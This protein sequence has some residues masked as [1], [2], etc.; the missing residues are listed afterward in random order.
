MTVGVVRD[1]IF[2]E[3]DTGPYHCEVGSRL[4]AIDEAIVQWEGHGA[5]DMLPLRPASEEELARVHQA[6]HLRRV[7]GT[8]GRNTSLDPDTVCSPR[9]CEVALLAAGSLIGL[10]DAALSGEVD[11]GFALVRPP[12]HHATSTQAMGFCLFNNVAAAAAHLMLKRGLERVLVVDWDVHHGNGTE[13]IFYSES[14]VLY[15][16]THQSP[17]YP[18]TG[19]VGAVGHGSAKGRTINVPLIPGRGDVEQLQA[20]EHILLPV[21]RQFRP[22]F[23]LVSAGFDAHREDPLGSMMVSAAGYAALT[24]RLVEIS[25]EFCPGRVVAA[26]EGGYNQAALGRSVVAVLG[27]LA[28]QRRED[29]LMAV[30]SDTETIAEVAKAREVAGRFWD[31]P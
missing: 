29:Q 11:H 26:L 14:R 28:G 6:S 18:G 3:H 4:A 31:L 10:C 8:A 12:G 7:A 5:L 22:Q 13:D 25:Q 27:A 9:S 20:F 15:F 23:I 21:A 17:L 16:S 19:Q 1:P 2:Q 30:A 24:Q